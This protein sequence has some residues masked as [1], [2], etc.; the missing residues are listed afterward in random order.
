MD[1][2]NTQSA[3]S[4]RKNVSFFSEHLHSYQGQI[5]TL[6]SYRLLR[7]RA[8]RELA[9]TAKLCDIGNGGVFNYDVSRIGQ[10]TAVDLFLDRI[11]Q[12]SYPANVAF[13]QGSALD[14][15]LPD[16]QFDVVFMENLIH[17]L[18]GDTVGACLAN[19][20]RC[21]AECHR[22]LKPGGRLVVFESCVPSWFESVE[23]V[24]FP[25]T[26]RVIQ[27]LAEHPPA[28]QYAPSRLLGILREHDSNAAVEKL[29]LGRWVLQ[30]GVKRPAALSPVGM[31]CFRTR[32]SA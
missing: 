1:R 26:R 21:F 20:R 31:W 2:T 7:E 23:R 5:Q 19:V 32:K 22:V 10:V 25:V 4:V 17:H 12:G 11:D 15:P 27:R 18:V 9:G 8:D 3:A 29:P 24:A 14:L 28:F 13:R 16:S 6:D 30:L